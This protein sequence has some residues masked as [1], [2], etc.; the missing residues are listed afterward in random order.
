MT[1][2][3]PSPQSKLRG[4]APG[5]DYDNIA[6]WAVHIKSHAS[7]PVGLRLVMFLMSK[8]AIAVEIPTV[9]VELLSWRI[10]EMTRL[11]VKRSDTCS[12]QFTVLGLVA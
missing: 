6:S 12:Q 7:D 10:T 9:I 3:N 2:L 4:D 8:D 5:C 11:R 1:Y